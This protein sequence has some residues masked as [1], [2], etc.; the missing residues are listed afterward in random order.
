MAEFPTAAKAK[1]KN[2]FAKQQPNPLD[3]VEYQDPPNLEADTKA[4][5][6]VMLSAFKD[7]KSAEAK[8]FKDATDSE[9]WF[10]VCFDSR[11][12]KERF[13]RALKLAAL[14]DKYL[15]GRK[16]ARVLGVDL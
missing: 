2:P 16:V 9:F 6:D 11:A 12:D 3:A 8:R 15:D 14:G 7:R 4:E 13:L 5:F 10:A 1:G